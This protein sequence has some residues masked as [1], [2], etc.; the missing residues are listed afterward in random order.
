MPRRFARLDWTGL[1]KVATIVITIIAIVLGGIFPIGML[2]NLVSAGPLIAFIV[3]G[4]TV[5]K[6]RHRSDIDHSG[7]KMPYYPIL[8]ILAALAAFL[9][10]CSLNISAIFLTLGWLGLGVLVYLF[11]GSRHS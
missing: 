2:A 11:Y 7:Y 9:L 8:P 5:L 6:L 4:L 10:L 3:A 1:P